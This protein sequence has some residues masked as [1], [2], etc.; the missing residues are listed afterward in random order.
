MPLDSFE[1]WPVG[2]LATKQFNQKATACIY[3]SF[4]CMRLRCVE[5]CC[6]ANILAPACAYDTRSMSRHVLSCNLRAAAQCRRPLHWGSCM[7]ARKNSFA[8]SALRGRARFA[9]AS[10]RQRSA[11]AAERKRKER[12]EGIVHAVKLCVQMVYRHHTRSACER[13]RVQS[14]ACP[15][16][17]AP[18]SV[19]VCLPL[20]FL[21]LGLLC[22]LPRAAAPPRPGAER[23]F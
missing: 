17:C 7:P 15:C 10:A 1:S 23:H 20:V 11:P 21:P 9:T 13:G 16:P 5:T 18:A 3:C 14:P 12:W 19:T 6:F 22:V 2:R 8:Y 4:S